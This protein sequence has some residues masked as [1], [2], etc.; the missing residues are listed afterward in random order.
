MN[1]PSPGTEPLL[2][3]RPIAGSAPGK[4]RSPIGKMLGVAAGVLFLGFVAGWEGSRRLYISTGNREHVRQPGDASAEVSIGVKGALQQFQDG[5][6]ARD[7]SRLSEFMGRLFPEDEPIVLCGTDGGE[8]I[9]GRASVQQFIGGDWAHWGSV[10][11]VTNDVVI[12][13]SGDVAWLAT[14]GTVGD[15]GRARP[16]RFLAVLQRNKERWLFRQIQFQWADRPVTL[17]ELVRPS[18]FGKLQIK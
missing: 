7:L 2:S 9:Q 4:G 3:S 17:H 11:L 10:R 5:Y 14:T 1:D 16:I 6:T 8:W 15:G 12:S 13:S 18:T